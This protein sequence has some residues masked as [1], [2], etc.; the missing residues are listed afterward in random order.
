MKIRIKLNYNIKLKKKKNR[1][2]GEIQ[3]N[4]YTNHLMFNRDYISGK[5]PLTNSTA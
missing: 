4:V 3:G 5:V 2:I 1:I